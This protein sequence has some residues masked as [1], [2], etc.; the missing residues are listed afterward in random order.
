MDWKVEMV[1]GTQCSYWKSPKSGC[2]FWTKELPREQAK[3]AKE[4]VKRG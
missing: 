2:V 4:T 3:V 1:D